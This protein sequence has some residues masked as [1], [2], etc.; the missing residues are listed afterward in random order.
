MWSWGRGQPKVQLRALFKCENSLRGTQTSHQATSLRK[1][2]VQEPQCKGAITETLSQPQG[3]PGSEE[4]CFP[5]PF[6]DKHSK[7][8]SGSIQKSRS[9]FLNQTET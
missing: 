9:P 2:K 6:Q 4:G 8:G 3:L 7:D 5:A 1:C